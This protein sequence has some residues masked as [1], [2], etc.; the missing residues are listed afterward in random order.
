MNQTWL[1]NVY[2]DGH[3]VCDDS[4]DLNDG[5]VVCRQLGLGPALVATTNSFF[6]Q[7]NGTYGMDNVEC[8]GSEAELGDCEHLTESN[9][10]ENEAAGIICSSRC[11]FSFITL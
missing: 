3:P 10:Q 8:V 4:W 5:N 2:M 6:G 9:C 1:G 7:A 11:L